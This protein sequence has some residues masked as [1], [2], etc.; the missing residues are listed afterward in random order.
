MSSGL[1]FPIAQT[2]GQ[3]MLSGSPTK[4]YRSTS[5]AR[6]HVHQSRSMLWFNYLG[7]HDGHTNIPIHGTEGLPAGT[8]AI[9]HLVFAT[10]SNPQEGFLG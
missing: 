7:A 5:T 4:T 10:L 8:V 1:V 9:H 3:V 6:I 2:W